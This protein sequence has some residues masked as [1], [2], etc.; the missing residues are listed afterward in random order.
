MEENTTHPTRE[1]FVRKM[2]LSLA[3]VVLAGLIVLLTYLI[4][5]PEMMAT[6]P[7]QTVPISQ[8][9]LEEEY[10]LRVNL[11]GVV[12]A[13]GMVD[14]RI[15][16]LD[17]SKAGQLLTDRSAYPKLMVEGSGSV[18]TTSNDGEEQK[19]ELENGGLLVSLFPNVNNAIKPGV[20]VSVAFGKIRLEAI[21]AR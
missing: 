18:L 17:A 13:G 10:G 7:A 3:V 1:Q 11:I 21:L 14:L 19:L 12:A 2:L 15:K 20:P 6:P 9:M 4:L 5:K 8:K 16:V